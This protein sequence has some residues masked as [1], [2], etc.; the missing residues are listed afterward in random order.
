MCF[1][2]CCGS[3]CLIAYVHPHI[4]TYHLSSLCVQVRKD[5]IGWDGYLLSQPRGSV[6]KEGHSV[7]CLVL[8]LP[9]YSGAKGAKFWVGGS[10]GWMGHTWVWQ[11]R[12]F[13]EQGVWTE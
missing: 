6:T 4:R 12:V 9:L 2:P 8:F 13:S 5:G 1:L 10:L 11:T 7:F 3:R